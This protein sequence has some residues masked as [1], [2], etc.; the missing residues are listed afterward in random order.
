MN[1]IGK[2]QWAK[3]SNGL[4]TQW[5]KIQIIN[6]IVKSE[7]SLVFEKLKFKQSDLLKTNQLL[8]PNSQLISKIFKD[9]EQLYSPALLQHCIG[10]GQAIVRYGAG[11]F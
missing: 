10:S 4:L 2:Y 5:E 1:S 3:K 9:V 7:L 11:Q 8:I 6:M